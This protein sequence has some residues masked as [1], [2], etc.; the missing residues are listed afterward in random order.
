MILNFLYVY[1]RVVGGEL[2]VGARFEVDCAEA[3]TE[4]YEFSL[5]EHLVKF[6]FGTATFVACIGVA[7]F[8]YWSRLSLFRKIAICLPPPRFGGAMHRDVST[9]YLTKHAAETE[10]P[11]CY[12]ASMVSA[13]NSPNRIPKPPFS[14]ICCCIRARESVVNNVHVEKKRTRKEFAR[15]SAAPR[16]VLQEADEAEGQEGE[17]V[18]QC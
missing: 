18:Q 11:N 12:V 16:P 1:V 6:V 4:F 3:P 10:V 2:V 14:L 17:E 15:G 13:Q 8:C 7:G 5:L 9:R